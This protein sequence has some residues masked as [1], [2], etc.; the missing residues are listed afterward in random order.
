M[1][2]QWTHA[3]SVGVEQIDEQHRE[4]FRRVDRLLDAMIANDR[5]EG[6]RLVAFLREYVQ[7][8]FSAEE[9]LMHA[10]NYPGLADHATEHAAFSADLDS[11]AGEFLAQGPTAALVLELERRVCGWL[12]DHVSL[13]DVALG[14]FLLGPRAPAR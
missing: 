14:R 5:A 10:R 12:R 7:L 4:L 9:A 8:H 2:L 11:L 3:L 6:M 13:R 1:G